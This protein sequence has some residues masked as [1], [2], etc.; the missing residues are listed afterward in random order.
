MHG[1]KFSK[2][3]LKHNTSI[4]RIRPD[5]GF[6]YLSSSR[7]DRKTKLSSTQLDSACGV[8]FVCPANRSRCG[9]IINWRLRFA[10]FTFIG[11]S[12]YGCVPRSIHN[13]NRMF[14]CGVSHRKCANISSL[15]CHTYDGP[16]HL[17]FFFHSLISSLCHNRTYF[18]FFFL[19]KTYNI[20]SSIFSRALY[21][22]S[23]STEINRDRKFFTSD[24]MI[25]ISVRS[26][27]LFVFNCRSLNIL[28]FSYNVSLAVY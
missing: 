21:N 9:E 24:I 10:L 3:T 4:Y 13:A 20:D 18:Y 26:N 2:L 17:R 25:I 16:M 11:V 23:T 28:F 6:A 5:Q 22:I 15:E 1:R 7:Y 27:S 19:R 14:A 12:S 8:T